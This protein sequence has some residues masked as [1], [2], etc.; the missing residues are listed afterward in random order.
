K[1]PRGTLEL[2]CKGPCFA[3]ID[4]TPIACGDAAAAQRVELP[5]GHYRVVLIDRADPTR[6][7]EQRIELSSAA[8]VTI[9]LANPPA[10]STTTTR[11]RARTR[12]PGVDDGG[13]KLP[14]WAGILGMAVGA[15]AI[16]A[17]GVLVGVDGKCPDFTDPHGAGACQSVL[18][19]NGAGYALL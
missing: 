17:G 1:G 6:R 13:R 10:A 12:E 2:R 19:T 7:T 8:T 3:A 11:G 15:A 16:I 9:A 4:A 14:R 18:N 5:A